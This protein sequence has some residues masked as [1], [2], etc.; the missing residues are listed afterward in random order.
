MCMKYVNATAICYDSTLK[1]KDGA[2]YSFNG[3]FNTIKLIEENGRYFV[4]DFAIQTTV[5]VLGTGNETNKA[6]N[7]I[8]RGD[9]LR[10]T[11]RLT[12]C[13]RDP[14]KR[15]GI[16]LSQF[17]IDLKELNEN[18]NLSVAC[19]PYYNTMFVSFIEEIELPYVDSGKYVLKV[20]VRNTD[21]SRDDT[22]QS[23]SDFTVLKAADE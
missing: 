20:L 5:S 22:I 19:Y 10:F 15:L 8:C 13:D 2:V 1:N 21:N 4:R 12:K 18:D 17:E 23:M 11:L 7:P 9:K 3:P 14:K 6:E 16:D